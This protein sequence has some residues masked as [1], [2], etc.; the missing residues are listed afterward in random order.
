L[1]QAAA[2]KKLEIRPTKKTETFLSPY[3]LLPTASLP[4]KIQNSQNPEPEPERTYDD[5]LGIWE[6][7]TR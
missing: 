4:P 1:R 2:A 5:V 6:I 7:K 3:S